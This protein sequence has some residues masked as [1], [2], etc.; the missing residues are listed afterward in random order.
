MK[1][2]GALAGAVAAVGGDQ[3]AF[4]GSPDTVV[5]LRLSIGTEFAYPIFA[6]SALAVGTLM[7]IA[8]PALA[9]AVEPRPEIEAGPSAVLHLDDTAPLAISTPG[10][11]ATIAAPVRSLFQMDSTALRLA[12]HVTWALR[13]SGAVAVVSDVTW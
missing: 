3:I 10:S 2:A 7:V 5:K 13:S 11:P 9:A 8:L 4:V 1:D 6:S 12:F